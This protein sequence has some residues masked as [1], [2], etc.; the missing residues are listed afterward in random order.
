MTG[1]C[2]K[3]LM[4]PN[5][6]AGAVGSGVFHE[7]GVCSDMLY[8]PG[9][10]VASSRCKSRQRVRS[11][12]ANDILHFNNET[13]VLTASYLLWLPTLALSGVRVRGAWVTQRII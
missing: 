5:D 12:A 1:G 11:G 10:R 13:P 8:H 7:S 3:D 2:R 4:T 6:L 9:L